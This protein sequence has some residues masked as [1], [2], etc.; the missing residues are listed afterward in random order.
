M[1]LFWCKSHGAGCLHGLEIG[2]SFFGIPVAY[3]AAGVESIVW[4]GGVPLEPIG[5]AGGCKIAVVYRESLV[6][7]EALEL[8]TYLYIQVNETKHG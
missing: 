8:R 3:I 6:L 7:A 4:L 2:D 1:R 5:I